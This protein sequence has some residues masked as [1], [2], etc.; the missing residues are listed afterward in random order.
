MIIY[1]DKNTN[2]VI[3]YSSTR[4]T[5]VDNC[6]EYEI[7]LPLGIIDDL[8]FYRYVNGELIFDKELELQNLIQNIRHNRERICFAVANRGQVWY[9]TLTTEQLVEL[10][11]WYQAWLDAPQTLIEP[12]TPY[13]INLGQN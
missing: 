4:N 5:I 6:N 1:V 12:E 13:W 11:S 7:D 10:Q 8:R 2:A 3:D 9:N